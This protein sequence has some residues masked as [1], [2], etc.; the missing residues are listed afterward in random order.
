MDGGCLT[1]KMEHVPKFKPLILRRG[2]SIYLGPSI[3]IFL[4]PFYH[5]EG[6]SEAG[7]LR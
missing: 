6:G 7:K 3:M 4:S 2:S 1:S 5:A